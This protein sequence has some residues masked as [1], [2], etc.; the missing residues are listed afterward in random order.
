VTPLVLHNYQK[1]QTRREL[2]RIFRLF[3]SFALLLFLGIVAYG[4]ELLALLTTPEYYAAAGAIPILLCAIL[5]SGMY[6]FAPGLG[7]AKRTRLVALVNIAGAALNTLLNLALIPLLGL[8]GAALATLVSAATVFL[9][10]MVLSQRLY[11]VPYDWRVITVAVGIAGGAAWLSMQIGSS[12]F[13]D[14]AIK[15]AIILLAALSFVAVGLV[16]QSEIVQVWA[17]LAHKMRLFRM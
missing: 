10:Y 8:N 5:L 13:V 2:A 3:V 17:P 12:T 7:I 9:L 6:F 16:R 14:I 1:P 4:S 11:A 15:G